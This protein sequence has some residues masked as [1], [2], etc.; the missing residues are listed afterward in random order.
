VIGREAGERR[1][2]SRCLRVAVLSI[3]AVLGGRADAS[4]CPVCFG[5]ASG[6]MTEGV[7][8]AIFVLLGITAGVLGGFVAF[9][10]H[11]LKRSRM[12]FGETVRIPGT[13]EEKLS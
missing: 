9:F 4:A 10:F 12:T 11:L 3:L 2:D 6:P 1:G 8:M 7:N 5:N 13:T